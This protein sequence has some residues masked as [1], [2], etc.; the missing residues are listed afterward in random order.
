MPSVSKKQHNLMALVANDPKAAK[1]LGIPQS[2]GRDFMKAD[3]GRKF[4]FGG[5]TMPGFKMD[6]MRP[7][8]RN[9]MEEMPM[10]RRGRAPMI[11]RKGG[12]AESKEMVKKELA[13]M[14]KKGAPKSMIRHEEEEMGGM[15]KGVR[16][17][18]RGG[19]T[20][21]LAGIKPITP[22][23]SYER[24]QDRMYRQGK[25]AAAQ[26]LAKSLQADKFSTTAKKFGRF[27]VPFAIGAAA[28]GLY[29]QFTMPED[30]T[31]MSPEPETGALEHRKGGKIH[32]RMKAHKAPKKHRYAGG[33]MTYSGG[34]SVFRKGA[35]GIASKGKT[36]GKM[37]KMAYGGKC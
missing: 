16:K 2:V 1:R 31:E 15:K 6:R 14:K 25:Q 3:K 26:N 7:M 22:Q 5:S 37:V 8:A 18:Q 35:D 34:G 28:K 23:Q 12:K 11:M 19:S 29:D 32:S 17:F 27:G 36:R 10:R 20:S 9:E 13:F 21:G 24:Y 4:N 30:N 33:G